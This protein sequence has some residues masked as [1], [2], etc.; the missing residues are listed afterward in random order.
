M[1]AQG[2]NRALQNITEGTRVQVR[3]YGVS[4]PVI[5]GQALAPN[6]AEPLAL[7]LSNCRVISAG[8]GT[9]DGSALGSPRSAPPPTTKTVEAAILDIDAQGIVAGGLIAMRARNSL[10]RRTMRAYLYADIGKRCHSAAGAGRDRN[11]SSPTA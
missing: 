6:F 3:A 2:S 5:Q 10:L 1:S 8:D 11:N 7:A 4:F 9:G